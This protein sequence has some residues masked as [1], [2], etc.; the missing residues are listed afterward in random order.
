MCASRIRQQLDPF[1]VTIHLFEPQLGFHSS[2]FHSP[3]ASRL[4]PPPP[5]T[6]TN[7]PPRPAQ[8]QVVA[9]ATAVVYNN[10]NNNNNIRIVVA[11]VGPFPYPTAQLY[12]APTLQSARTLFTSPPNPSTPPVYIT[13]V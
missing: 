4:T 10:N 8:D 11:V 1:S 7:T 3:A 12:I 9:F 6:T 2:R 13:S 5:T